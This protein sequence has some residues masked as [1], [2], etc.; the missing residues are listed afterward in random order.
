MPGPLRD[1]GYLKAIATGSLVPRYERGA[2]AVVLPKPVP[3]FPTPFPA[4]P[5]PQPP[6]EL[7]MLSSWDRPLRKVLFTI[8]NTVFGNE[9]DEDPVRQ[10]L[11]DGYRSLFGALPANCEVV[12]LVRSGR[13]EIAE[14]WLEE[15]GVLADRREIRTMTKANATM[16]ANDP[17]WT[18]TPRTRPLDP[19]VLVEPIKYPRAGD[20]NVADDLILEFGYQGLVLPRLFEAGN[21][22]VGDDFYFVG[23]DTVQDLPPGVLSVGKAYR[24][25]EAVRR[26]IVVGE[27][28]TELKPVTWTETLT[29]SPWMI[30]GPV[31]PA[32][33]R[34]PIF[35]LDMYVT[36]VGRSSEDAPFVVMVGDPSKATDKIGGPTWIPGLGRD[37]TRQAEFDAV[38]TQLENAGFEV[39]RNPLPLVYE[40]NGGTSERQYYFASYNNAIVQRNPNRVLLPTYRHASPELKVLDEEHVALWESLGFEVIQLADMNVF[41]LAGGAANCLKNVLARGFDPLQ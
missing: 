2:P 37:P 21:L 41:A 1:R 3:P 20:R 39:I 18:C 38:A 7:T 12:V 19:P 17:F 10:R 22:L 40:D 31:L 26:P 6:A 14:T 4:V 11:E 35:H 8:P 27:A 16:W 13:K 34:Q 30:S 36:L 33:S 25:M 15:A 29:G 24:A 28:Q 9:G 5:F 32:H 23:V